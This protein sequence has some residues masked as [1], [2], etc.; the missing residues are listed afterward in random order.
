MAE[1]PTEVELAQVLNID[2]PDAWSVTIDRVLAAAI[3]AVKADV[4]LWDEDEYGDEPDERLAQ[5]ALRMAELLAAR[6]DASPTELRGDPT[7][8][9]L[10]T[11]HRRVFGIA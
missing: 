1:W 9:R 5:A 11:G 6:P 10:L 2:D 4:G 8:R 3:E 7:Y